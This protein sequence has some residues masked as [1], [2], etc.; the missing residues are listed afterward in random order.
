MS[1]MLAT[2][3]V[4]CAV[5]RPDLEGAVAM[6]NE[7]KDTV[8]GIKLGLEFFTACGPAGVEAVAAIGVPIFLDLKLHDIP[9]TVAG[10]VRSLSRL[11]LA[12]LTIHCSGGSAMMQAAVEAAEAAASPPML[13]GVTV[14]TSLDD[15]DL[16]AQ[17]ITGGTGDQALRLA[18]LAQNAGCRAVVCSPQEIA[19]MRR[20]FG[21]T[22][23]LVVPGIRPFASSDDQKRTTDPAAAL[24]AGADYLVIGRPIT[25]AADPIGAARQIAEQLAQAA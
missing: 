24:R 17:G 16:A 19:A 11:P 20:N 3:P 15:D 21:D 8:G 6:A 25:A 5:D 18:G 13:L 1:T 4:F 7:L 14:L 12:M 9:N 22:L 23:K 2:N 10:A